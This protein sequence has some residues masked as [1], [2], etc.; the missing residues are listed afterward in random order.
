MKAKKFVPIVIVLAL[1]VAAGLAWSRYSKREDPNRI[2]LSGNIELTQVDI[3]FKIAGKLVERTVD[4]G[5]SVK[6][7]QFIA[8]IDRDILESQRNRDSASLLSTETQLPQLLTAIDFQ[9]RTIKDDGELHRA[10]LQQAQTQLEKLLAGSRPQEVQYARAQVA[11]AKS[12]FEQAKADWDRAQTLMKNDDISRSQYDQYRAR[13]ESS[14]ATL[15]RNQENLD[16]V[17]EGPRKEDIEAARAQV[18]RAKAAVQLS[19][20]QLLDLRRREQE[21]ATRKADIER[22]RAQMKMSEFQ[23]SDTLAYSPVTG[24]VLSKSAD[25]GEILAAG[26]TVVSIGDLDHPWLRG[27]IRQQDLGRV[28]FGSKARVTTDS[29]PGKEY[30][31]RVSFINSEAEFTP[32]QIQTPEERVKLVYRIKIDLDNPHHELKSNMPVDAEIILNQ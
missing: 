1:A 11:D 4:E 22:A 13:Y 12:L 2:R 28:K 32:K 29:F 23:L 27:Y 10:E 15:K 7:G 20:A 31:G 18:A 19:D 17:V 26:T 16:L 21:I 14:G 24:I 9:K 30:R 8:R 25:V 6:Q 3:A 5:E